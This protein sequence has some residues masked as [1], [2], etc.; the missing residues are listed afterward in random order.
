MYV[1]RQHSGTQLGDVKSFIKKARAIVHKVFPREL[2]PTRLIEDWS[3]KQKQ[4]QKVALA[5]QKTAT[6]AAQQL[7]LDTVK[8]AGAQIAALERF[9]PTVD[10]AAGVQTS[11]SPGAAGRDDPAALG[12]SLSNTKI[13]FLLLAAG[14]AFYLIAKRRNR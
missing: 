4:K 10:G 13:A 11:V 14:G 12:D 8:K 7:Q 3:E 2:S 6:D 9:A 5:K 1:T